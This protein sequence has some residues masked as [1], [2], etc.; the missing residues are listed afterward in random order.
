MGASFGRLLR[1]HRLAAGLTQEELA[2]RAGLSVRAVSD[3]ERG[4]TGRPYPRSVRLLAA[5][6]DLADGAAG[7]LMTAATTPAADAG[8]A[9]PAYGP[10]PPSAA[11]AVPRQLPAP[12]R[13]FV[14]RAA[15][16]KELDRLLETLASAAGADGS[17]LVIAA[18]SGTAGVGKT[19]LAL[20][21]AHRA[22]DR[23]P[24]G[25]LHVNLQGFGPA[26]TPVAAA[27]VL[28]DVLTAFGVPA[29]QVPSGSS[30]LEA[31]Y[32]SVLAGKRVLIV[33][34]NARDADQVRPLLPGGPGCLVLVTSRTQLTGLIAG[35]AAHP[36]T[37]DV[38]TDA[39]AGDLLAGR[40]GPE[41]AAAD[42]AGVARLASLCARLPLALAVVAARA[43][44]AGPGQPLSTLAD[45]L[46]DER[47]R[48]DALDG[49]D[50][51][52][53][54]RAVLSWSYASLSGPAADMFRLLGVHPGPHISGPAAASLAGVGRAAAS[55]ALAELVR[56]NLVTQ[57]Q[58][59]RYGFHDLLRAYAA[60]QARAADSA[61]ARRTA[62]HRVLD[63]Y[64]HTAQAA[65]A[66]LLS[67]PGTEAAPPPLAGVRPEDM[68]SEEQALA[69]FEASRHVLRAVVGMA[70]SAGF[71]EH[72]WQLPAAM[73]SFMHKRGY[74][75]Q[76][77][78]LQRLGLAA[79]L[80]LGDPRP[81]ARMEQA[82]G[83]AL[84]LLGAI[85]DAQRHLGRALELCGQLGDRAAQ[86]HIH[87]NV[88]ALLDGQGRC[89]ESL[90][91]CEQALAIYTELGDRA[92]QAR[93]LGNAGW[94]HARL[95]DYQQSLLAVG[96]ALD[97][98]REAGDQYGEATALD[99]LG[100][101]HQHLGQHNEALACHRQS[102]Q[103]FRDQG[104][105][106][107]QANVLTHL[108]DA[109]DA[110]GHPPAA[111]A[112]WREALGILDDLQ[113]ADADSVRARL[114][115]PGR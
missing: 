90:A 12:I 65:T 20:H 25:Q 111:R 59:D 33:A 96:Q 67:V 21:W 71:D 36:V 85:D 70:V 62:V 37:L 87:I 52:S 6:L 115:R 79:A 50:A 66:L 44:V 88:A 53:N 34:D 3:M 15:E 4:R 2:E 49:G 19:A 60:E 110:A 95:G 47:G 98:H 22:S 16:L 24:D 92:W 41:H 84:G 11:L 28:R 56:A 14:G 80:R 43:A 48:L 13:N 57:E 45:E 78:E 1:G 68:T 89:R 64:L 102:L 105:R 97:L 58:R 55:A 75:A 82:V 40:L 18:V 8:P 106:Y 31:L 83:F 29:E 76:D 42:L 30:A 7:R 5:A 107:S 99:S 109:H 81:L 74:W 69:W 10:R 114:R 61:L 51:A 73:A 63:H 100:Y 54:V 26:E 46:Q 101:A 17:P 103:L 93:A 27:E 9:A 112:A 72:A 35:Q 113:H 86:A 38:L 23:F 39:E 104:H 108:G 94:C 32:R 91:R 77:A